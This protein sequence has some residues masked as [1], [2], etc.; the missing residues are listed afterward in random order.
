MTNITGY[1]LI[2][3]LF[4]SVS[5]YSQIIDF[6]AFAAMKQEIP[7][8]LKIRGSVS[9]NTALEKQA[10]QINTY[11]TEASVAFQYKDHLLF[12][13]AS[14]KIQTSDNSELQNSGFLSLKYLHRFQKKIFYEGYS[15]YQ[16]EAQRGMRQRF[17]YGGNAWL[18]II[19]SDMFQWTVAAGFFNE[20]EKWDFTAVPTEKRKTE[21]PDFIENIYFK[22][23]AKT[24][25]VWKWKEK[26]SLSLSLFVQGRPDFLSYVRLAPSTQLVFQLHKNLYFST[27]F[28]GIYDYKPVVPIDNFFFSQNNSLLFRF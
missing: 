14:Q 16:W 22:Y 7:D 20:Y 19:R 26:S 4:L 2:I 10:K 15:Q 23:N 8:S 13:V 6:D 9:F 24:R 27:G 11:A 25:I 18:N 5:G 17:L 3:S 21:D 1:I 12:P 28:E